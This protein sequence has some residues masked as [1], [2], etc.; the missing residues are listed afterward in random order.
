MVGCPV[1]KQETVETRV[2]EGCGGQDLVSCRFFLE[3]GLSG[4]IEAESLFF[5]EGG[6]V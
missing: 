6:S 4:D 2:Q 5:G 1:L 3:L